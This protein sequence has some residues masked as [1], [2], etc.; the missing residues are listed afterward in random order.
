MSKILL[1]LLFLCLLTGLLAACR[2]VVPNLV[3]PTPTVDETITAAMA[4]TPVDDTALTT[5]ELIQILQI[6]HWKF[7]V[8]IPAGEMIHYQLE[9]QQPGQ[10]P[11]IIVSFSAQSPVHR[12]DRLLVALYPIDG[13]L[14]DAE[15]IKCFVAIG[16]SSTTAVTENPALH[17]TSV[18]PLTPARPLPTAGEG[19]H[20]T[21]MEFTETGQPIPSP[22]NARI[23]LTVQADESTVQPE[24]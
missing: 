4:I 9:W 15:R 13:S 5:E 24:P 14:L 2:V 7:D 19:A 12:E 22:A 23:V 10:P 11:L 1:R 20:F 6:S 18:A 21:L 17:Y 16:G 8:Q 3:L